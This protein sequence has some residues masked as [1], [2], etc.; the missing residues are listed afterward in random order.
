M[1][2]KYEPPVVGKAYP[3]CCG[4]GYRCYD[5]EKWHDCDNNGKIRRANNG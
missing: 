2:K 3:V 5:G 4:S 1:Y